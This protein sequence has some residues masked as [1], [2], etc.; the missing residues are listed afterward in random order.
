MVLLIEDLAVKREFGSPFSPTLFVELLETFI[1]AG[2]VSYA[3]V[4][5]REVDL[6]FLLEF[7]PAT[8]V[9]SFAKL[10]EVEAWGCFEIFVLSLFYFPFWKALVSCPG[11]GC[12]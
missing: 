5:L 3:V 10:S 1:E 2:L 9:D 6:R 8:F 7:P 11:D 4:D 12:R